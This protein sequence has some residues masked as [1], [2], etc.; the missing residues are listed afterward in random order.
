[1]DA[2]KSIAELAQ[3][4]GVDV[5]TIANALIAADTE[6]T[7]KLVAD[8]HGIQA[9]ADEWLAKLAENVNWFLDERLPVWEECGEF[10][11][12]PDRLM[13]SAEVLIIDE[14]TIFFLIL[15]QVKYYLNN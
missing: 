3:E 13:I 12:A 15:M 9:E 11:D 2:G 8:G 1:L 14:Y 6:Y 5:Q 10:T 7:N 4:R